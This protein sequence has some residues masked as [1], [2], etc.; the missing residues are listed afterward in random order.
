MR[1]LRPERGECSCPTGLDQTLEPWLCQVTLN[2]LEGRGY[3][4]DPMVVLHSH[5]EKASVR[6]RSHRALPRGGQAIDSHE[7]LLAMEQ[8]MNDLRAEQARAV[9]ELRKRLQILEQRGLETAE[10]E[11]QARQCIASMEAHYGPLVGE[12]PDLE[13]PLDGATAAWLRQANFKTDPR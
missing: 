11:E 13:T 6:Y 8:E 4:L 7:R 2:T 12:T 10:R 3:A 5:S 9:E 1:R